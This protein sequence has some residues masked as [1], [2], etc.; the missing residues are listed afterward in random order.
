[1]LLDKPLKLCRGAGNGID[2]ACLMTAANML[3]GRGDAGDE[4]VCTCEVLRGFILRTNDAMHWQTRR[5]LYGP[6]PWSLVGTRTTDVK[7]HLRRA[8]ILALALR[9]MRT[10]AVND[11]RDDVKLS[12]ADNM[13]FGAFFYLSVAKRR[14]AE[15]DADTLATCCFSANSAGYAAIAYG[16]L[17]NH[18]TPIW[19]VCRDALVEAIAV[20]NKTPVELQQT[21][22]KLV[23]VLNG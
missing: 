4:A 17:A 1:M 6:L 5:R 9:K 15:A 2:K 11:L 20:G 3:I 10:L 7:V 12:P 14:A 13:K 18:S 23:A 16:R 21:P 22:E 19:E 8:E